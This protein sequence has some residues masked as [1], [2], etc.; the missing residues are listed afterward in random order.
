MPNRVLSMVANCRVAKEF[1]FYEVVFGSTLDNAVY[2]ITIFP[3]SNHARAKSRKSQGFPRQASAKN[4][5]G[6]VNL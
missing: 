4:S 2:I 3:A 6:C 1:H 5:R